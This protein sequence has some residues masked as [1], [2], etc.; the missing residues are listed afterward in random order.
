[1]NFK[2][3]TLINKNFISLILVVSFSLIIFFSNE[4]KYITRVESFIIDCLS[5]IMYPQKWYND[6]LIVKNENNILKQDLV[7]LKMLNA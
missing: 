7:Q 2:N 4:S 5:L 3:T 6:L 1:M